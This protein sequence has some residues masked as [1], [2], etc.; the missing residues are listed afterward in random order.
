MLHQ[1]ITPDA[2]PH[3]PFAGERTCSGC[4]HYS[5]PGYW[6][7]R[8]KLVEWDWSQPRDWNLATGIRCAG[9]TCSDWEPRQ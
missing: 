6:S 3:N 1:P 2:T 5:Q 7:A 9:Q 8:C 4:Q